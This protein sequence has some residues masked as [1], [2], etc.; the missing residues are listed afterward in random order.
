MDE[1][2]T[3][4]DSLEEPR[5]GQMRRMHEAIVRAAP[6]IDMKLWDYSGKLIGYGTYH[7]KN[8]TTEGDWFSLGLANR[9]SYISRYSMGLRDGKHL[10]EVYAQ[11]LPG[12]KTGSSCLNITKPEQVSDGLIEELA[13]ETYEL[14]K[15]QLAPR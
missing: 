10:V 8:K 15:E 14:F 6:Q 12:V 7:Y 11:R 5:R 4:I 3:Y 9:K 13:R 1:I 2:T